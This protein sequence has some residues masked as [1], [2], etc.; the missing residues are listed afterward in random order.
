MDR[1]IVAQLLDSIDSILYSTDNTTNSIENAGDSQG[2]STSMET[3]HT[4]SQ[5]AIK[6]HVILIAATNKFV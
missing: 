1:R 2:D 5:S 4:E 6:K 3:N